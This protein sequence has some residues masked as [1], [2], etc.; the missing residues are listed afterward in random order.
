[1]SKKVLAALP[2][3]HVSEV[4]CSLTLDDLDRINDINDEI[5]DI[6]TVLVYVSESCSGGDSD[7]LDAVVSCASLAKR[8]QMLTDDLRNLINSARGRTAGDQ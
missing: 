1:M 7:H 8:V 3:T 4:H 2:S 5:N 6:A